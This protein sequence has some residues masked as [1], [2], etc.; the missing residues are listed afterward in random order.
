LAPPTRGSAN[1]RSCECRPHRADGLCVVAGGKNPRAGYEGVRA[2]LGNLCNVFDLD[3]AIDLEPD[4]ALER[5]DPLAHGTY[6]IERIVDEFLPT[7]SRIDRHNEHQ[8]ELGEH[9]VEVGERRRRVQ[10]QADAAPGVLDKSNGAIDV[11]GSLGMETDEIGTGTRKIRDDAIHRL[12]HQMH[13]DLCLGERADRLAHHWAHGE[14]GYVMI[15]HYVKVHQVGAGCDHALDFLAQ[16]RKVGGEDAGSDAEGSG[17][18]HVETFEGGIESA[19]CSC[20]D[21]G[22]PRALVMSGE[23]MCNARSTAAVPTT[24]A[25]MIGADGDQPLRDH[26]AGALDIRTGAIGR[27]E[28]AL[29]IRLH[30]YHPQHRHHHGAAHQPALDHHR[31]EQSRAGSARARRGGRTAH[32]QATGDI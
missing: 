15:V 17:F 5:F 32:S 27:V 9:I 12:Y 14:I 21:R 20:N 10:Y 18:A 3:T 23:I 29:R 22:S 28:R 19:D 25:L 6:L 24:S 11:L 30:H 26:R 4:V 2:G 16:T 7:E 31:F 8:I 1:T 13:V